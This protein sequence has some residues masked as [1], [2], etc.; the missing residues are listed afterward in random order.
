MEKALNEVLAEEL[1]GLKAVREGREEDEDD[2]R[3]MD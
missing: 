1:R 2:E 3:E